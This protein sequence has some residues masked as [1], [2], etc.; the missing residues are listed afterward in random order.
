MFL[1]FYDRIRNDD[2]HALNMYSKT[3]FL[4]QYVYFVTIVVLLLSKEVKPT[5]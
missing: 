2:K 1:S 4:L 5:K 3:R